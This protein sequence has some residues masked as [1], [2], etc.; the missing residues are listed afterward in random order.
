MRLSTN[1]QR[2]AGF[3]MMG[4]EA[5]VVMPFT[6]ELARLAPEDFVEQILVRDLQVAAILVGE[7]FR[8]GHRQS[9]NVKL[10]RELGS[11]WVLTW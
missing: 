3:S 2:I 9:G 7:N 4:M 5:A 6:M 8:F 11:G 1:T 10:L